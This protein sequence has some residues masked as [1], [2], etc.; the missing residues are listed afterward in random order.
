MGRIAIC[1]NP[2]RLTE[3]GEFVT[4]VSLFGAGA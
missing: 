2:R 3:A 1:N 4:F